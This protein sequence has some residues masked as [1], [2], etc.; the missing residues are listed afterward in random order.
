M[1]PRVFAPSSQKKIILLEFNELCPQLLERWMAENRLP[2]FRKFHECSYTYLTNADVTEPAL[3]E[4]WIQWYSIHTGLS[5]DQHHVFHLTDGAKASHP[6]LYSVLLSAGRRVGSFGSMNVRP[7]SAEGSFFAGDPWTE[8]G[9]AFPAEINAYNRFIGNQVREYSNRSRT[10]DLGD[11]TRFGTFLLRNGLSLSTVLASVSELARERLVDRRLSFQRVAILDMLQTDVFHG[12]YERMKPDFASFFLNSTA[13]LQHSYWRHFEPERFVVQ[14]PAEELGVYGNAIRFGYEA[15]DALVGRFMRL[16]DR[17]G[18]TLMF[19]TALSQQPFLRYEARGGQ[20][21]YRLHDVEAFL[22]G[23]GLRRASVDPTMTHQYMLRFADAADRE[24]ALARLR[25]FRTVEG[26]PLFGIGNAEGE[27]EPK[28]YFGCQ[29]SSRVDL[30]ARVRD[31][32]Q[33]CELRFGDL[34]YRIDG[35]KSGCHHP[36]GALW[37]RTGTAER[38]PVPV[39]ILD[40]FPTILGW[41]GVD[42]PQDE[43][44]R[45]GR[46]LMR[47]AVYEPASQAA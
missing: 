41:M 17:H 44:P 39:S 4:P 13:H 32:E 16:A 10:S 28:L 45:Q 37:I 2:N 29:V 12:V 38:H 40:V 19:M 14:P 46:D 23:I 18:A 47:S 26:T 8:N 35:I 25:A 15:M 33:G 30:D 3:L 6:D 34:F 36:Q 22:D 21:F 24:R 5:Y 42:L 20:N 27:S 1:N 9:D 31:E 43:L 7:F 11:L